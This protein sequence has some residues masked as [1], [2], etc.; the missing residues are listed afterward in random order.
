[1]IK[2]SVIDTN[3]PSWGACVACLNSKIFKYNGI[4]RI[5]TNILWEPSKLPW[6]TPN[7]LGDLGYMRPLTKIKALHRMYINRDDLER[8]KALMIKRADQGFSAITLSTLGGAKDSRSMGHCIQHITLSLEAK[9]C[10][11]TV[12]YRSTEVLK[13]FCGDLA[14]LPQVFDMLEV[15][16]KRVSF[17]FANAYF[18]GIYFPML[19]NYCKDPLEFLAFIRD[20]DPNQFRAFTNSLWRIILDK[21]KD[22]PYSPEQHQHTYLWTHYPQLVPKIKKFLAPH[23]KGYVPNYRTNEESG[24]E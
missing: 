12:V 2:E 5:S 22:H 24:D 11:A 21:D 3:F 20:Y 15:E 18:S 17:F 7:E 16:P 14:F 13:K 19:M 10:E 4:R 23:F 9:R 1:M 8:V 6:I